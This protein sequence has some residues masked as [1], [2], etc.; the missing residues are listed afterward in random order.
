MNIKTIINSKGEAQA[1]KI[2]IPLEGSGGETG[3]QAVTYLTMLINSIKEAKTEQEVVEYFYVI[4]GYALCCKECRFL[5]E[6]SLDDLMH[7]VEHIVD[8]EL[9]RVGGA[10]EG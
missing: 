8:M 7:M 3:K 6:K 4:A 2:L 5:T 1:S 9:S 10:K